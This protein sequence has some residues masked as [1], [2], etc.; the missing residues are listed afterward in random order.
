MTQCTARAFIFSGRP[1]P[2][3]AVEEHELQRLNSIWKQLV[4]CTP[5]TPVRPRLG[6]RGVS[7]VC[8][9][10]GKFT[11]FSGYVTKEVGSTAECRKDEERLFER[12]LLST[13]PENVIPSGIING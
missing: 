7:M 1:D 11:A 10:K 4:P 13:A 2:T 6:Y 12:F 8:A 5:S 3:W 9:I